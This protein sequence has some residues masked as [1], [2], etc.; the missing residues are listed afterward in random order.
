[1]SLPCMRSFSGKPTIITGQLVQGVTKLLKFGSP[2]GTIQDELCSCMSQY[3]HKNFS[4]G[5]K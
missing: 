4:E 1:M 2:V 5:I 3:V